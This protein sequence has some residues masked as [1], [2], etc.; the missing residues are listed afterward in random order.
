MCQF[1]LFEIICNTRKFD[2]HWREPQGE[3]VDLGRFVVMKGFPKPLMSF[4]NVNMSVV[5]SCIKLIQILI[6][7]FG[8][9]KII[10]DHAIIVNGYNGCQNS[11]R[12][13][14]PYIG[15][16]LTKLCCFP[17]LLFFP[18]HPCMPPSPLRC[19]KCESSTIFIFWPNA[20]EQLLTFNFKIFLVI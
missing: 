17:H 6:R 15:Y 3:K 11:C 2:K 1:S 16:V 10:Y 19:L 9:K 8:F 7:F 4:G 14:I 5:N 13:K 20:C 12:L 18:T